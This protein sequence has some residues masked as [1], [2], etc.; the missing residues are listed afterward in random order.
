MLFPQSNTHRLTLKP[1]GTWSLR[2]PKPAAHY[3]K[4]RWLY[5]KARPH[6]AR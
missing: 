5:A 6:P 2:Q 1:D 4:R 3:L